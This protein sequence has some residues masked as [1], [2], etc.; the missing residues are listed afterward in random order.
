MYD[1]IWHGKKEQVPVR[2]VGEDG[3]HF[4][5]RAADPYDPGE[6]EFRAPKHQVLKPG[7]TQALES[8]ISRVLG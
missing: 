7:Q 4:I 6:I 3:E 8:F 2:I 1:H 5:L